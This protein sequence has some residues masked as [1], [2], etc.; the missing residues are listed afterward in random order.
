M[1]QEKER[2][3]LSLEMPVFNRHAYTY[4]HPRHKHRAGVYHKN[5]GTEKYIVKSIRVQTIEIPTQ[6][7]MTRDNVS[8]TLD[9]WSVVPPCS[10]RCCGCGC[11]FVAVVVVVIAFA[12]GRSGL[13]CVSLVMSG[14]FACQ[15]GV[16]GDGANIGLGVALLKSPTPFSNLTLSIPLPPSV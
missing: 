12:S 5:V 7:V 15:V 11:C 16:W 8:L 2:R 4:H 14:V 3:E 13:F 9:A 10:F 6:R 1:E